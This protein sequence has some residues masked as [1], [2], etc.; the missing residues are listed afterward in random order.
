MEIKNTYR[1]AA[2]QILG[3]S[4]GKSGKRHQSRIAKREMQSKSKR[5][6]DDAILRAAEQQKKLKAGTASPETIRTKSQLDAYAKNRMR[7]EQLNRATKYAA[8]EAVVSKSSHDYM[9]SQIEEMTGKKQSKTMA[10]FGVASSLI[11][12]VPALVAA[13]IMK[14]KNVA[15]GTPTASDIKEQKRNLKRLASQITKK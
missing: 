4:G 12:G 5:Y 2:D 8:L 3:N 7:E 11:R 10:G 6:Y 14:P 13:S 1:S 9:K 15:S